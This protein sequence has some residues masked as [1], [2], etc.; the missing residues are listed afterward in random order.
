[1]IRAMYTILLSL[2]LNLI[3]GAAYAN[4]RCSDNLSD[5]NKTYIEKQKAI[6]KEL[7]SVSS[8]EDW[9]KISD[10]AKLEYIEWNSADLKNLKVVSS[11]DGHEEEN[12][13]AFSRLISIDRIQASPYKEFALRMLKFMQDNSAMNSED[14]RGEEMALIG[15]LQIYVEVLSTP[16][17]EVLGGRFY[18]QQDVVSQGSL[19]PTQRQGFYR[20]REEALAK[21]LDVGYEN[22][23]IAGYFSE[24]LKPL[25]YDSSMQYDH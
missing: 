12:V 3:S 23:N 11:S 24:S 2:I 21:G 13:S 22:Y 9:T 15:T 4:D 16:S 1:M 14:Y 20:T 18:A 5:P 17:G 7:E 25:R 19:P 6:S 8:Y 10:D